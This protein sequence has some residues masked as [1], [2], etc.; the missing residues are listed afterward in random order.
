MADR[1]IYPYWIK[2]TGTGC[3][4]SCYRFFFEY[5]LLSTATIFNM[6]IYRPFFIKKADNKTTVKVGRLSAAALVIEVCIPP[7]LGGIP[8]G[9]QIIQE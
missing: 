5:M 6:G 3:I 8:Q 1:T 2:R 9:L 7:L 4:G